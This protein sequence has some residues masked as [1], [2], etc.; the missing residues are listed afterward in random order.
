M[1]MR[2]WHGFTKPEDA[3]EYERMLRVE[4]LPGIHRIRG[5]GGAWLLR[6]SAGAEVE[7]VTITTWDSWA[8]I[9]EFAGRG[10]TASVIHPKAAR[11]LTRHDAESVHFDASW[12]A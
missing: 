11:L 2:V 9:E 8:A 7:F 1:I 5:Y 6:R 3:D 4:I 10:R 12:V